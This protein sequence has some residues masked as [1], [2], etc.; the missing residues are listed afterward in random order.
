M[1]DEDSMPTRFGT[2]KFEENGVYLLNQKETKSR[3]V[4]APLFFFEKSP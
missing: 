2:L 3:G 1:V 4:Q